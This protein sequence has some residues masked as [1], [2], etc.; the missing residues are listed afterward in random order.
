MFRRTPAALALLLALGA[1]SLSA[2]NDDDK[3]SDS[4]PSG[5]PTS[6]TA[7]TDTSS[8]APAPTT[9]AGDGADADAGDVVI[10][11][12]A[13][14]AARVGM[15][16]AEWEGTGL[17]EDGA[18]VCE[19]E[20]IHWAGEPKGFG[21]L[22]DEDATI[23]QLTVGTPGPHTKHGDIEVGS[24]YGEL[25]AAWP[26]LTEPVEDGFDQASVY[27]PGE[28]DGDVYIAFLLD[29]PVDEVTDDTEV[30]VI[31]VSGGQKPNFQYDC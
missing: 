30:A 6:D 29:A 8:D 20:L 7:T 21:V 19:G 26:D 15:T 24:T 25:K 16:R 1:A 14:G 2:C 11:P 4:T 3:A 13:I 17:F 31:G 10:E 18:L 22:T 12:G 23:T 28:E 9:D 27:P 5:T